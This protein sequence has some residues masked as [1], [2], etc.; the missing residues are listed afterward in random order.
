LE[1]LNLFPLNIIE[2]L[3]KYFW[4]FYEN[5]AFFT[6]DNKNRGSGVENGQ[7]NIRLVY[8]AVAHSI[9]RLAHFAGELHTTLAG[10][11]QYDQ[12]RRVRTRAP[13]LP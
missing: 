11:L 8:Y 1:N 4:D 13:P 10:Y 5:F 2:K 3:H 12:A 9:R 7:R 6:I